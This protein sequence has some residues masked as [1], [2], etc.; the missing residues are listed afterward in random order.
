M[1]RIFGHPTPDF[2]ECFEES[3]PATRSKRMLRRI[4]LCSLFNANASKNRLLESFPGASRRA[5]R[6]TPHVHVCTCNVCVPPNPREHKQ[7]HHLCPHTCMQGTHTRARVHVCVPCASTASRTQTETETDTSNL[8]V[9]LSTRC[10]LA[11]THTHTQVRC[12]CVCHVPPNPREH[13][14]N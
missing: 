10:K 1:F 3:C 9:Q 11:N 13:N 6:S 2:D 5:S 7:N 4:V 14:R 8:F 12:V